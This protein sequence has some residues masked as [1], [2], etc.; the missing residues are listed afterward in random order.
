MLN[1]HFMNDTFRPLQ[2][3]LQRLLHRML[4]LRLGDELYGRLGVAPLNEHGI[5][6]TRI[7]GR[8]RRRR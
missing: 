7:A 8:R 4:R 3:I 5:M 1:N 6:L 2:H